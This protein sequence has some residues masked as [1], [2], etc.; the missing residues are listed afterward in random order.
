M[1]RI[2]SNYV[3]LMDSFTMWAGRV[4]RFGIMALIAVLLIEASA[5]YIFHVATVWSVETII[6]IYGGYF[7]LGGAFT[8]LTGGHVRMDILYAR[9]S[10]RKQAIMNAA[11][12]C[13]FVIY[14]GAVLWVCTKHAIIST[15][16]DQHSGSSWGPPLWPIKIV[17]AVGAAF[18]LLQGISQ[19]IKNIAVIRGKS[20]Q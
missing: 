6:F 13:F 9:W 3:R 10:P 18:M 17:M 2:L 16:M 7:L 1:P 20:L 14:I 11:F 15:L 5:R 19:F 12:F 4:V 8:L